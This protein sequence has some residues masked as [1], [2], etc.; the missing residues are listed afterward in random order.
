MVHI[1]FRANSGIKQPDNMTYQTGLWSSV[2]VT[3]LDP[4]LIPIIAFT[5]VGVSIGPSV[6]H[7][8]HS[9]NL[10]EFINGY[11]S[12]VWLFSAYRG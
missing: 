4:D 11:L 10:S 12:G 6:E 1:Y 2:S 7:T 9:C 8:R 3:V 5:V